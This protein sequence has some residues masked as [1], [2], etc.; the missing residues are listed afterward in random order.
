MFG[1]YN[2]G[3][4]NLGFVLKGFDGGDQADTAHRGVRAIRELLS[5]LLQ[6]AQESTVT[7]VLGAGV[8]VEAR[9]YFANAF[10]IISEPNI[11]H[12]KITVF[13]CR[14]QVMLKNLFGHCGG[15]C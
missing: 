3:E 1:L 6:L 11:I 4:A 12:E 8:K 2:K 13:L 7:K 10:L 14:Y 9:G 15:N 5:V